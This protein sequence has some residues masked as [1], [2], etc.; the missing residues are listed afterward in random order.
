MLREGRIC[1]IGFFEILDW[2]W[3]EVNEFVSC[4]YERDRRMYKNLSM[5]S[6]KTAEY[7]V[8]I[9]N[10]HKVDPMNDFP[11]WTDEERKEAR[12]EKLKRSFK[13]VQEV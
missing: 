5:I 8:A 4:C 3:G 2:T 9:K 12:I 1:G 10:G 11:F 13:I 6:A 7:V